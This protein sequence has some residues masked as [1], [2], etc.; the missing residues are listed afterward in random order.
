MQFYKQR[1]ERVV[2]SLFVTLAILLGAVVSAPSLAEDN[3]AFMRSIEEKG[4][5]GRL[6]SFGF[7]VED[8]KFQPDGGFTGTMYWRNGRG[9]TSIKGKL[10]YW[11][12]NFDEIEPIKK[13]RKPFV[14]PCHIFIRIEPG[15]KRGNGNISGCRIGETD[16]RV[17]VTFKD[18]SPRNAARDAAADAARKRREEEAQAQEAAKPRL[19]AVFAVGASKFVAMHCAGLY[20]DFQQLRAALAARGITYE[21]AEASKE[22]KENQRGWDEL[23]KTKGADDVCYRFQVSFVGVDLPSDLRRMIGK[24]DRMPLLQ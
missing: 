17:T 19:Q 2:R 20:V 9:Y 6:S 16:P 14:S 1:S 5:S 23:L 21:E 18:P 3:S 11:T 24:K 13:N 10:E 8:V 15:S 4:F 22:N 12:L 7:G